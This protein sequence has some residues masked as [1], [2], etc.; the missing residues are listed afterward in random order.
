MEEHCQ[1]GVAAEYKRTKDYQ[2][3]S[4]FRAERAAAWGRKI[5]K[6]V[7][8]ETKAKL[9]MEE[10]AKKA[11]E[12]EIA[13]LRAPSPTSLLQ[14]QLAERELTKDE[15]AE[16]GE[17]DERTQT[18][19]SM[20]KDD[21]KVILDEKNADEPMGL[22]SIPCLPQNGLAEND[23]CHHMADKHMMLPTIPEECLS[24]T[25][26]AEHETF[27][28][29][30]QSK[31]TQ[32]ETKM[33]SLQSQKQ[34]KDNSL[35]GGQASPLFVPQKQTRNL[36][37]GRFWSRPNQKGVLR[38]EMDS[39]AHED[40]YLF[41]DTNTTASSTSTSSTTTIKQSPCLGLLDRL[42]KESE[43]LL[44]YCPRSVQNPR[45]QGQERNCD[46]DRRTFEV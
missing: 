39:D 44:G 10:Q 20:E 12:N 6:R 18:K 41:F 26:Q 36:K 16:T 9:E 37:S 38:P 3:R 23:V 19:K 29:T 11:R 28:P 5:A 15:A 45:Q 35:G 14:A 13:K 32:K 46:T 42:W 40:G 4:S 27:H 8:K 22:P 43:F 25:V 33:R 2:G 21:K 7:N 34:E 24:P 31:Q 1:G 30:Q 17:G